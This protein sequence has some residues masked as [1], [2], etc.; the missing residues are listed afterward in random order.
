MVNLV[1]ADW[2]GQQFVYCVPGNSSGTEIWLSSLTDNAKPVK[3]VSSAADKM[4]ANFS[5]T[6]QLLAYTSNES[7]KFE[8]K[9]I[10]VPPSDRV[11]TV[12]TTGGYEPRWRADGR[13]IYYLSP[14]R[15]LMAVDVGAGPAFGPR[16]VKIPVGPV[17][18]TVGSRSGLP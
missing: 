6:G 10:T 18:G 8:V 1:P 2:F 17:Y 9:V 11:W 12:S 14:D 3:L 4:H 15:K 13:E 7:G 16:L 5:P